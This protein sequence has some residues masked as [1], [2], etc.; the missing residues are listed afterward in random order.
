[1]TQQINLFNPAL[2]KQRE[3]LTANNLAAAAAV[4][5]ALLLIF[6]ALADRQADQL[7]LEA[8]EVAANLRNEQIRLA[9]NTKRLAEL[10]PDA[11]LLAELAQAEQV[12]TARRDVVTA[13]K[14]G[15]IGKTDGFSEY[16]RAFARQSVSGLWL[17]GFSIASG[18][19][20]MEIRGRAAS[21]DSVPAYIRRLNGEKIVSG[22]SFAALDMRSQ[23]EEAAAKAAGPEAKPAVPAKPAPR[24][25]EFSLMTTEPEAKP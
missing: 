16:M 19:S 2:Q 9:E 23:A 20:E 11:R 8:Q 14:G 12:L 22:R 3:L 25:I 1:M 10:K 4:L 18:G 13:L 7:S 24:Y 15:A 21:P 6:A 5:L 17:T